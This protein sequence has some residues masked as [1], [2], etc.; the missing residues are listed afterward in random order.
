MTLKQLFY[1]WGGVNVSL[2]HAINDSSGEFLIRLAHAGNLAGDYWGMPALFCVLVLLARNSTHRNDLLAAARLRL[3]VRRLIAGFLFTWLGVALLKVWLDFPRPL[4]VL[5]ANV[6]VFGTPHDLYSLPSGH[7]AY[8]ALVAVVSWM[9]VTPVFRPLLLIFV[10]WVGWSRVVAGAHF[11]ADVVAGALLGSVAG[12]SAHRLVQALPG[13]GNPAPMRRAFD[14]VLAQARRAHVAGQR[15]RAFALLQDAHVLGQCLLW[16][17]L[18][19]H[20]W[21]LR[22]AFAH[23]DGEEMRGQLL[24]IALVPIGNVMGRLPLGNT[25]D[26]QVSAFRPMPIP[27]RLKESLEEH[28]GG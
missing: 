10:T 3:Q 9:L 24:R 18:L 4:T 16:P 23:R 8:A 1:D 26:A 15:A 5:G 7:T 19:S 21:M 17:H 12:M 27:A 11:P 20:L 14:H 13:E 6:H 22:L 25:G 2:F 28:Y